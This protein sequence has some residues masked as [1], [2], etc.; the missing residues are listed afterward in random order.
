M[1][2]AQDFDFTNFGVENTETFNLGFGK[3]Q[4]YAGQL[5]LFIDT[6][7][8]L[9]K[10][11]RRVI[12]T[13]YQSGRLEELLDEADIFTSPVTEIKL[14]PSQ[15]SI[16]LVQGSLGQGWNL[17]DE[18]FIFTDAEIFGFVKQHR[19]ARKHP[20]PR[21]KLYTDFV[22]GDYV[23]HVEHGIGRFAG[24][25][26]MG[27]EGNQKEYMVLQYAGDDRLYVPT[28]QIDRVTR[29]VG[30]SEH[31][32]TLTRLSTQEWSQTKKRVKEAVEN[33]A[34][35]L[36]ALYATRE[37]ISGFAFS[38]D[39]IWQKE[40]EASF[41]YVE[42]PDQLAALSSVKED[43][44]KPKPMD[45]LVCGDVGYGK[46]EIAIRAA[47]KAVMDGKQVAVLVP[48]T[49]L[50]QQHYFT[51]MQRMEAFPVK[52]EMLSRFRTQ[53]EQ[54]K[55]IDALADGSIDICV[56]THRLVQ[57]DVIFKNLGLLIIDEEQRFGV[58]H[59]EHIK[60]MKQDIHVLTLSATPIPRTLHMALAGVRDMSTMDTPP[61][62]RLPI[63]T[64]VAEYDDR[65]IR[66]AI[67]KEL[68]RNGQVFFVHNRVQTIHQ[69]T[70]RMKNLVPEA[71]ISIAHGQM[72]ERE[73]ENVMTD[74]IQGKSDVLVCS[75]IIESGLDMPNVN[76]LIVDRADRFGL[77]QMYQL[78]GRIGRGTN[79]AYAYLLYDKNRQ[80]TAIAQK[81]LKIIYEATELG[82]GFNIAMKD[83]EI[84]GAGSLLGLKQSGFISA[85]GFEL[86]SRLLG[87]AIA[88]LKARQFGILKEKPKP[89]KLP[90][91]SI[92]LPF[93]A[94]I[95]E[96]YIKDLDTRLS[97]YQ[98][99]VKVVDI[100]QVKVLAS[101]FEDR[102][103][104]LPAEVEHL[105][106]TVKIKIL[107]VRA[108][109]Q[110]ISFEDGQI[111][112]RR[113]Q[114]MSFDH[115]N[116]KG[117]VTDGVKVGINHLYINPKRV[118]RWQIILERI[119][120]NLI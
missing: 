79:H 107:A 44:E 76:T 46:T 111:V 45:R 10:Q 29:Y 15:Y 27:S 75:T 84:R 1:R 16:T 66:E 61:E 37:V 104:T 2:I 53:K 60:K 43:M 3:A 39:N 74:F 113:F 65:L 8:R 57:R 17:N 94:Y 86:Y 82:A 109:I 85:V 87:E 91:P 96:D 34:K 73:L 88:E 71:R 36:L 115:S 47:F 67:L 28:D 120:V 92:E 33:V 89:S 72:S 78:R 19:S 56:G 38:P 102:F 69:T 31:A 63:K 101:D 54:K 13:S 106:Y 21:H 116:I 23:V 119:L 30:S 68:E 5:P 25:I 12:L 118:Q 6:V 95:P 50:A 105:L 22:P 97:L 9:L 26:T 42:T 55:I 4:T 93:S 83:L 20:V 103:G 11:K 117:L 7:K 108:A 18:T 62:D 90:I 51:F 49:V 77:S 35:D 80:L 48:T 81:R 100:E 114:G 24:V 58:A 52:V 64:F 14:A 59:K 70:T 99:L 112:V 40:F 98:R 110:S 41:P 32:P